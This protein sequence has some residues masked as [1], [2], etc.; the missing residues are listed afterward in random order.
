M[1]ESLPPSENLTLFSFLSAPP[2]K[3]PESY[4]KAANLKAVYEDRLASVKATGKDGVRGT[5]F[6]ERVD[7]EIAIVAKKI[8]QGNF[9]FTSFKER[10]ILRGADK[11]PR[12][13]S[14]PTIRDR[15]VMRA[16][17]DL[18][19]ET[20]DNSI[21]ASPHAI[22]DN[23]ATEISKISDDY[24]FV[25][26]D[27]RDFYPSISHERLRKELELAKL[28]PTAINLC[29]QAIK[30]PTGK[31]TTPPIVG[32]PQG[33]SISNSLAQIFMSRFDGRMRN[34]IPAYFRYVDDI[35]CICP[36]S[37]ANDVY[38]KVKR[39]LGRHGLKMHPLGKAGK[40]EIKPLHEHIEFLG[41]SLGSQMISIKKSSYD[42]MFHN[43]FKLFTDYKYK[44]KS[45]AQSFKTIFRINLKITGCVFAKKRRGWMFF[46]SRTKNISQ[47]KFLDK[48]VQKHAERLG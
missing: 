41:Y 12:Q 44:T 9:R 10:L 38:N 39:A 25:R 3:N 20:I 32:I 37:V 29:M 14:I 26:I 34:R 8:E 13:I 31:S 27:V 1:V 7:N 16:L 17:C 28:S 22:V 15:I 48:F 40:S 6:A 30:T 35:L 45:D 43:I 2:G 33:L 42:R 18:I 46:F 47:L 23:I 36:S 19:H 5:H 24:C 21:G 11:T 4:F